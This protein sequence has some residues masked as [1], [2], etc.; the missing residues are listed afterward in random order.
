M[1]ITSLLDKKLDA[2]V[3]IKREKWQNVH[4]AA[5]PAPRTSARQESRG[6]RGETPRTK[7]Q[8]AHRR[9]RKIQ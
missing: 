4:G 1:G 6:V 2:G 9:R 7:K 8:K 3:E 5:P